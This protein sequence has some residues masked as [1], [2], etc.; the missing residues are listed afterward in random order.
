[1]VNLLCITGIKSHFIAL[2]MNMANEEEEQQFIKML[3]K[4]QLEMKMMASFYMHT[5]TEQ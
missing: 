4:I 5:R 1:M 2:S 3:K